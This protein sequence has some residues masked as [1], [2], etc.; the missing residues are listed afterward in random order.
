MIETA[1]DEATAETLEHLVAFLREADGEQLLVLVPRW[2]ATLELE[3]DE[4]STSR[5]P[6]R[7][8]WSWGDVRLP[9]PQDLRGGGW[10]E[11]LTGSAFDADDAMDLARLPLLPAVLYRRTDEI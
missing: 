1:R 8:R 4:D 11:L 3:A 2:L 5:S 9:L 7:S 10:Q 6:T